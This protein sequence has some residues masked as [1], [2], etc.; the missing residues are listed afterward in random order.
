M[1]SKRPDIPIIMCTGF[2]EIIN[3]EEAKALG[4]KEFI[5]KPVVKKDLSRVV[6]KVLDN[7]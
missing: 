2:S 4:I 5:M 7:G 3:E 1:L 6:R